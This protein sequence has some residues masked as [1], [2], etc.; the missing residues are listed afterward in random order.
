MRNEFEFMRDGLLGHTSFAKDRVELVPANNRPV[1]CT[2]YREGQEASKFEIADVNKMLKM[3]VMKPDKTDWSR[4]IAFTPK[5]YESL[6][7]CTDSRKLDVTII[8]D[9]YPYR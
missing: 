6:C 9:L 5:E 7:L 8:R 1:H 2:P 3:N 4:S